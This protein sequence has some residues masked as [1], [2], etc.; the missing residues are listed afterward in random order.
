VAI[1][2][3]AMKN[4]LAKRQEASEKSKDDRGKYR[5]IFKDNVQG[6]Q[7]WKPGEGDHEFDIIPYNAGKN[8]PE[9][10]ISPGDP[11]YVLIL[12]VHRG[13]G[14]N[15]DS[16]IC[17]A[18]TYNKRCPVCEYQASLRD[19]EADDDEIKRWNPTR[20]TYYNVLVYDKAEQEKGVQVLD[21]A[22]YYM[23][24]E[25][26][27]L[28]R[29]SARGSGAKEK[30]F[31]ASP[32]KEGK[33]IR[34]TREGTRRNTSYKAFKFLD[35][36]YELDDEI[37]SAVHCLD[38]IIHIPSYEEVKEVLYLGL[39]EE[40]GKATSTHT[41]EDIPSEGGLRRGRSAAPK[42]EEQSL[43]E[44]GKEQKQELENEPEQA[45]KEGTKTDNPPKLVCPDPNGTFGVDV[46]KLGACT[47][48]EIWDACG[49][50]AARL[51]SEKR[52]ARSSN[53]RLKR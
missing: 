14:I 51:L 42:T 29:P 50:E 46:E 49:E 24:P 31:F 2:R 26:L 11:T 15:E 48:C 41:E 44:E 20:R 10:T 32:D 7:L 1:D 35:R 21:I 37:L 43:K 12:W 22:H 40:G 23:E 16:F 9:K 30:I 17:L 52:A 3:S 45:L 18:K 19:T 5:G 53:G 39:P 6:L 27:A 8:D 25:L 28:S 13:I 33:S 4:S 36:D 34:F 47:Q 38:E